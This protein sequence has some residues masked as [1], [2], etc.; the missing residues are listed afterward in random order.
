MTLRLVFALSMVSLK[1]IQ[2]CVQGCPFPHKALL[3]SCGCTVVILTKSS[4]GGHWLSPR[5][6]WMQHLWVYYLLGQVQS[7]RHIVCC[8]RCSL[9]ALQKGYGGHWHVPG[10]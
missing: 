1:S 6:L 9:S 3:L 2:V 8:G 10:H 5:P 4:A 7:C